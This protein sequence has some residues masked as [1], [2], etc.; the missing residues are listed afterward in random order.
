MGEDWF[1]T[2]FRLNTGVFTR[3]AVGVVDGGGEALID[4]LRL[5]KTTDGIEGGDTYKDPGTGSTVTAPTATAKPTTKPTTK[6][7]GGQGTT[8]AV[9]TDPTDSTTIPTDVVT[10]PTQPEDPTDP[11]QPT[12]PTSPIEEDVADTD[13]DAEPK[14]EKTPWLFIGIGVGAAVLIAGGIVVFLLLRKKKAE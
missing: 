6:P 13:G 4:N 7:T 2:Y 14:G 12:D 1:R 9:V 3:I 5:F 10:D 11:T 8:S